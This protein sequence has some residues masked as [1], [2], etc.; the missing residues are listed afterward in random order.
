MLTLAVRG[1]V[2]LL[3][4]F[5]ALGLADA[6]LGYALRARLGPA[7]LGPDTPPSRGGA[8]SPRSAITV[9]ADR[10]PR[11]SASRRRSRRLLVLAPFRVPVTSGDQE[12]FLLL[13]LYAVLVAGRRRAAFRVLRGNVLPGL[14]PLL[15]LPRALIGLSSISLLWSGDPRAGTIELLFFL[16]PFAVLVAVVA[17]APVADWL[18]RAL[19]RRSSCSPA[20]SRWSGISQLWTEKPLLRPRPRGRERLHVLLPDDVA[21]RRLEHLRTPARARD[22]RLSS[23]PSGSRGSASGPAS[24]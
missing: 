24:R 2:P 20:A 14:P 4:G 12:A 10:G 21:L 16:F 7:G 13:P 3:A 1:R 9:A 5:V 22:R 17:R 8:S 6:C 23:R 15:A 18:P 11:S 19:A